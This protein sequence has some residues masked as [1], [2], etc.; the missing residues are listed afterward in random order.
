MAMVNLISRRPP[1][2]TASMTIMMTMMLIMIVMMI[3]MI[4]ITM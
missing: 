4:M 2:Y 3:I 1:L